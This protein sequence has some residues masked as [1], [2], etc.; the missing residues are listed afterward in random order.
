[1]KKNGYFVN[2]KRPKLKVDDPSLKETKITYNDEVHGIMDGKKKERF[3]E[4][5]KRLQKKMV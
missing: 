3:S 5:K 2:T 1:M 4:L